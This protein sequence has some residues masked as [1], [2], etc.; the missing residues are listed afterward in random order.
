MFDAAI[1]Q[2]RALDRH[3]DEHGTPVGPLHGLPIS[4]K[5]QFRVQ[6][7]STSV[8]YVA[9]LGTKETAA[10]ESWLVKKLREAGAVIYV[11]TNVP[12]SL[13]VSQEFPPDGYS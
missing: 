7:V 2:A 10:S 13:M 3:M 11:K 1:S 6:G 9:W 5:D 8:G 4:L 12:S